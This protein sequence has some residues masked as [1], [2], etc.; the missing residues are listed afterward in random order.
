MNKYR[1]SPAT[2]TSN[3]QNATTKT[4]DMKNIILKKIK[5]ECIFFISFL[6]YRTTTR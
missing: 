5:S 3:I 1:V 6:Y 4:M 2:T